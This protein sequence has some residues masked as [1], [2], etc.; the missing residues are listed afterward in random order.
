MTEKYS[1]EQ[2]QEEMAALQKQLKQWAAE[3]YEKDAP[4]VSDAEYDRAYEKLRE[5]ETQFP[6][7]AAQDSITKQVGGSVS[8]DFTKVEH[9]V[10]ML[11]MG[12]VFSVAELKEFVD[13][14]DQQLQQK[15]AYNVELK[16][17]GL[18]LSLE[19]HEG[20]LFRASTRGNGT[21]GEDVTQNVLEIADVPKTLAEPLTIE[22]RGEC[23]M[24]KSSFVKLNHEREQKGLQVF[25]NPR[26]AAAGSLRQLDPKITKERELST[27]IYTFVNPPS[28]I[29][30]Q[31]Q[32]VSKMAELGFQTNPTSIKVDDFSQIE[33]FINKYQHD[34]DDLPY[35]I[36]GVVVKVNNLAI[37]QQ[38]G[39]TVKVPRW[40]IAY[41][42]EPEEAATKV[43]SI[44]WT[45]GRTGVVT[46]TAV[47]EPV[48][49][50]GTTVSR[51]TLHNPD[52]LLEKGVRI[53][54]TVMVHKAG[55]IIPEVSNVLTDLRPKDSVP[56]EIPT[57]CPSCGQELVHLE[58][59]VALRCINP[60]C[61]A[62]IQEQLTHFA[63]RNAMNIMGLGPKI[64]EQLFAK[65][66]VGDVADLYTLDQEKLALL[67]GFKEKSIDNLLQSIAGSKNNSLE[68]LLFG[69]GIQ[70]VGAKAALLLAKRFKDLDNLQ[71]ASFAE[72]T[73]IDTIGETIAQSLNFY[74][75]QETVLE[76]IADLKDY[77]VNM[78]YLGPV[79]Q[80]IADNQFKGKTVV[81]TGKF[82]NYSR[83]ELTEILE[84][85]GAKVTGSVSKKTDLVIYGSDAG[86]KLTKAND[87]GVKTMPAEEFIS[88]LQ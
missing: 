71:R 32:A 40:E 19:Y 75:R 67:D 27:F 12:D 84:N 16:I 56:Y 20:K 88:Q 18:S 6:Q 65:K 87:L 14:L 64:I 77:G 25:A 51:A 45:V 23:Y 62:Q 52:Y 57:K 55:D 78:E 61:P 41:K 38:L 53:N 60:M 33:D 69:L 58:D 1:T 83:T 11:S 26:N 29:T 47:M 43:L 85:L 66:L 8:E 37:Q 10:P 68:K 82:P 59:E 9:P 81:I 28:E 70:H 86:S 30:G 44:D 34:R 46:P 39:N 72:I 80:E 21:I 15:L 22:V 17:D 31:H 4:E 35:G 13:K 7:F 2:A 54:D 63:S 48:I 50:A 42:F 76:L 24:P 79:E 5:L 49:L 36:D 3:Y 74:F 73:A